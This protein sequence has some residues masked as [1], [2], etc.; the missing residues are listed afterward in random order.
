MPPWTSVA[1]ITHLALLPLLFM[2]VSCSSSKQVVDSTPKLHA[3]A[4]CLLDVR[5]GEVLAGK[6][7][8]ERR[9]VASTQKLLTALVVMD[10]NDLGKIVTIT[11]VDTKV[12]GAKLGL[13]PDD[14]VTRH[15]LLK[16]LLLESANDASLALARDVAGGLEEFAARMNDRARRCGAIRSRFINPHGLTEFGQHSSALDMAQI[17]RA[18]LHQADLRRIVSAQTLD[19]QIKGEITSLQNTNELLRRLPGCTGMKTG[20]TPGAGFCLVSSMRHGA[21][22]VI[23]VQLDSSKKHIY[24]DAAQAMQWGLAR[25]TTSN[26]TTLAGRTNSK[27]APSQAPAATE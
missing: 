21:D 20:L 17:A 6:R 3:E 4:W 19:I 18:A 10:A 24:S 5:S 27:P 22:E 15:D 9:P 2:A 16:A 12:S 23:L 13:K 14:K 11:E 26:A 7:R 8:E 1:S 25:L